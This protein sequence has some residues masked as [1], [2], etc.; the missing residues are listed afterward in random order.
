MRL[1]IFILCIPIFTFGSTSLDSLQSSLLTI[2]SLHQ[3]QE[4]IT[5]TIKLGDMYMDQA[6]YDTAAIQYQMASNWASKKQMIEEQFEAD[7]KLARC[8]ERQSKFNI[9]SQLCEEILKRIPDNDLSKEGEILRILAHANVFQG[10]FERAFEAQMK[11]LDIYKNLQDSFGLQKVYYGLGNNFFYQRQYDLSKEHFKQALELNRSLGLE[12]EVANC[13]N[14]LGSVASNEQ[15]FETALSLNE[16]SLAI[17][18]KNDDKI[19]IAWTKFN[20]ATILYNLGQQD[21]GLSELQETKVLSKEIGEMGLY[22]YTLNS[23]GII[24]KEKNMFNKA[25]EYFD[26]SYQMAKRNN[27]QSSVLELLNAFADVYYRQQD[28]ENYSL[29]KDEYLFIKDSIY[30]SDLVNSISNL[31]KDFEITQ[32][33]KEKEIETLKNEKRV[34][35]LAYNNKIWVGTASIIFFISFCLIMFISRK[36][37]KEKNVLLERKNNEIKR[38]IKLLQIANRD[39]VKYTEIISHDLREPLRNISGFTF[40]LKRELKIFDL[41]EKAKECMEFIKNG[42][43]QMGKTLEGISK[44]SGLS[45]QEKEKEDVNVNE[46]IESVISDLKSLVTSTG[47]TFNISNLPKIKYGRQQL[48][49]IFSCLFSNSLHFR[50]EEQPFITVNCER[51][52]DDYLFSVCDNG[53]GIPE[54]FHEKIFVVFQRLNNRSKYTGAGLGL[55]TCKKIIESNGGDIYIESSEGKGTTVFF[56]ITKKVNEE[57]LELEYA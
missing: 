37:T 22:G 32:L 8:Y 2:D 17:H 9:L 20:M 18:I 38:Q 15:D 57:I 7:L 49:Q 55:S 1:L 40:L 43:T 50:S 6:S 47:A 53:I 52:D 23:I 27:D 56:S 48:H 14:A 19:S 12:N 30:N 34:Q 11:A 4:F 31:K 5:T 33:Q 25:L 51:R 41:S 44:Y 24:Y 10:N 16:Q 3:P 36:N 28:I 54:E 42:T 39:L 13:L 21:R 45:V 46:V 29:Y 26:E 35:Q